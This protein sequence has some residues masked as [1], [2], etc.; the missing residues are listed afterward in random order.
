MP[1]GNV[2]NKV[3]KRYDANGRLIDKPTKGLNILKMSDGTT[4]KVM[5]K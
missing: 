1:N 2:T 4:K 3:V 5:V